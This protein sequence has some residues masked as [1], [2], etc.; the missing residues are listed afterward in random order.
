MPS[1]CLGKA[2]SLMNPPCVACHP[3]LKPLDRVA[4][5]SILRGFHAPKD[6]PKTSWIVI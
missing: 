6:G 5:V 2:S 3:E 1:M 4:F